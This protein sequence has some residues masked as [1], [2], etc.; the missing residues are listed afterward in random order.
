MN[1]D[2]NLTCLNNAASSP[3]YNLLAPSSLIIVDKVPITEGLALAN[4]ILV[5]HHDGDEKM[6]ER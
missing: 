2:L 6:S 3:L 4:C 1:I 5:Y